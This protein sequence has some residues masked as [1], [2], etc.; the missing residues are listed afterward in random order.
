M[1]SKPAAGDSTLPKLNG[2]TGSESSVDSDTDSS[3]RRSSNGRN[4]WP[5]P[6][7]FST[8][9]SKENGLPAGPLTDSQKFNGHRM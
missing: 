1:N 2:V 3:V 8:N 9:H 7:P 6:Q 5:H 4:T